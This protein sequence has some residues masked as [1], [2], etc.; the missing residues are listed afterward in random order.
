MNDPS[1]QQIEPTQTLF[2]NF[3]EFSPDAIVVT[4]GNGRITNVNSQVESVFGYTRAELL[5][6]PV[7]TLLPER[8]R[9]AHPSHRGSYC[10]HP[11]IRPMGTGL[12]LYGRRKDGSEFPVDIMLSPVETPGGP[13]FLSV[14]RD[15]SEKKLG[16][17]CEV[18]LECWTIEVITPTG[19]LVGWGRSLPSVVERPRLAPVDKNKQ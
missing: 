13:I 8:F 2:E 15:I 14:V 1:P 19:R 11:S 16:Q 18:A 17:R 5:G 4:D 9:A 10:D 12:E 3:F 7:E 6:F